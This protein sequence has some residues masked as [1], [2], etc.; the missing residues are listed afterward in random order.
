MN[1]KINLFNNKNNHYVN[2]LR[3]TQSNISNK[4][5]SLDKDIISN[6]IIN[7]ITSTKSPQK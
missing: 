4:T 1:I 2:I 5:N 7:D 6:F 3:L